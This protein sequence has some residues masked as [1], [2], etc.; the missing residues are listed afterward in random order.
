MSGSR[1]RSPFECERHYARSRV[2]TNREGETMYNRFMSAA[3]P[4]SGFHPPNSQSNT[5]GR[6][7][8]NFALALAALV[9]GASVAIAQAGTTITGTVTNEQGAPLPGAR[10]EE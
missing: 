1:L 7:V 8:R 3:R 9:C 4:V 10:S 6:F 2:N 5:L